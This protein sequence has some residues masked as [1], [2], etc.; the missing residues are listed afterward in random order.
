[1]RVVVIWVVLIPPRGARIKRAVLALYAAKPLA[2][3][4]IAMPLNDSAMET[5]HRDQHDVSERVFSG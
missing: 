4:V 2:D 3:S 1:V 5:F